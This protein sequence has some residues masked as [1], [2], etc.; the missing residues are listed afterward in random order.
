MLNIKL[1]NPDTVTNNEVVVF[2][3]KVAYPVSYNSK[4]RFRYQNKLTMAGSNIK[5]LSASFDKSS[6]RLRLLVEAIRTMSLSV[7]QTLGSGQDEAYKKAQ[8]GAYA[9]VRA[10]IDIKLDIPRGAF[11]E[12]RASELE[13]ID[14]QPTEVKMRATDGTI[15]T[16]KAA[17]KC[18]SLQSHVRQ[19]LERFYVENGCPEN[20][21]RRRVPPAIKSY[22]GELRTPWRIEQHEFSYPAN[23]LTIAIMDHLL[24]VR[25]P[26]LTM[27][28]LMELHLIQQ[29]PKIQMKCAASVPTICTRKVHFAGVFQKGGLSNAKNLQ[30][31]VKLSRIIG[32][33]V[34]LDELEAAFDAYYRTAIRQLSMDRRP[35]ILNTGD[36]SSIFAVGV[37]KIS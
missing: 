13:I 20:V 29:Y 17:S 15:V 26:R 7:S 35:Y 22:T 16:T 9:P 32:E 36:G 18:A 10:T 5:I 24:G 25:E 4:T 6:N 31:A 34:T 30:L 1:F 21:D 12:V 23:G 3:A 37:A 19:F 14:M 2:P 11:S 27:E 33:Q 28:K 8:A